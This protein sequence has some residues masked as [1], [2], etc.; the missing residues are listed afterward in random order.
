[1][2][3]VLAFVVL[4]CMIVLSGAALGAPV[5]EMSGNEDG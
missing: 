1:M 4:V 5:A 3:R 2:R